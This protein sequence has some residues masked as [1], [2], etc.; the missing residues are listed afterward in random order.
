[1]QNNGIALLNKFGIAKTSNF[2]YSE[3]ANT[4]LGNGFT[5][6]AGNTYLNS[7]RFLEGIVIKEDV[8]QGYAYSFI[9]GIRIY[10]IHDKSLLCEKSYHCAYYNISFIKNEVINMIFNLLIDASR[11]E[12]F[13]INTN[14][15]HVNIETL[16]NQAFNQDQRQIL[17]SQTQKY[18][19]E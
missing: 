4:F 5:S 18:L 8:G 16:V 7:I 1:M 14:D 3:S 2:N 17:F 13:Q 6:A 9:N 11:K 12:G 19:N 15:V 10:A